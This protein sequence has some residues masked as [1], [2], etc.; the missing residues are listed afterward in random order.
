MDS[1]NLHKAWR[2]LPSQQVPGS[3]LGTVL[4]PAARLCGITM[5]ETSPTQVSGIKGR[6]APE[7]LYLFASDI[8]RVI[9]LSVCYTAVQTV[10]ARIC[11][12]SAFGR[13]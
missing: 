6:G 12:F 9:K 3:A 4:L 5:D 7:G 1:R 11:V 13:R 2:F 8:L 10:H